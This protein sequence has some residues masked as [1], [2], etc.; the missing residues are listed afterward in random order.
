MAI[1]GAGPSVTILIVVGLIFPLPCPHPTLGMG[2]A[3]AKT[4]F[5]VAELLPLPN[6]NKLDVLQKAYVDVFS[7]LS[8]E[9]SCSDFFGGP[10]S[11]KALNRLVQQLRSSC[12]NHRIAIRMSGSTSLYEDAQSNLSF[13]L[14][15][16]AE[17]NSAGPFFQ[18][19]TPLGPAIPYVGVFLPNTREARATIL[20]HELGHLIRN[21]DHHWLLVDDGTDSAKSEANTDRVLQVCRDEIDS[22]RGL[23]FET[24]LA[25]AQS[26]IQLAQR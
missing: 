20:L 15:E 11:I 18:S 14:F 9:N 13:R 4:E 1:K 6:S 23:S 8:N 17:I 19:R 25:H 5:V 16:R 2:D 21:Q 24:E 12:L 7:I 22:L 3:A 26:G 10:R